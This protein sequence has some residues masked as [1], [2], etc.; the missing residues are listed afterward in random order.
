MWLRGVISLVT[1]NCLP[2]QLANK[3][4]GYLTDMLV[5]CLVYFF[6]WLV[7]R[8]L[9]LFVCLLVGWFVFRPSVGRSVVRQSVTCVGVLVA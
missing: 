4:V 9:F 8:F 5:D 1:S 7:F 3:L 6:S 2:S